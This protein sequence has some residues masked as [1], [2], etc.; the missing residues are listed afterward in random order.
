ML[1]N[2]DKSVVSGISNDLQMDLGNDLSRF[3]L[4]KYLDPYG[5]AIFNKLQMD[6][7]I[8]DFQHLVKT[9]NDSLIEEILLLA[10]RCK[11]EPHTYLSFYG[12]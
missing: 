10:E 2:E 8:Q 9:G 11:A 5:D 7:L 1:E 12:D 6:D 4:L 3:K